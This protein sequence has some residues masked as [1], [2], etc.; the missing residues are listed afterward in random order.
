MFKT[1]YGGDTPVLTEKDDRD[2]A[3]IHLN[4]VYLNIPND[5]KASSFSR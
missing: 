3:E 1:L 5:G 4:G 2:S